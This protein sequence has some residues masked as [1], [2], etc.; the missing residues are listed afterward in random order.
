MKTQCSQKQ[1][2]KFILKKKDP[3]LDNPRW[4]AFLWVYSWTPEAL[5]SVEKQL[6]FKVSRL[7]PLSLAIYSQLSE[8]KDPIKCKSHKATPLLHTPC[9]LKAEPS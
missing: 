9:W 5:P 2:N 8:P 3:F 1:I 6:A 7:L 4:A